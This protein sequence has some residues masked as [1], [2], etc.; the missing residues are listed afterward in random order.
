MHRVYGTD[1]FL[2][3]EVFSQK[4]KRVIFLSISSPLRDHC[5]RPSHHSRT[6][7]GRCLRGK[8]T[9]SWKNVFFQEQGSMIGCHEL[10][11]GFLWCPQRLLILVS[12][13]HLQTQ[14]HGTKFT[15]FDLTIWTNL[16]K[17]S[18]LLKPPRVVQITS[19]KYTYLMFLVY[20][21]FL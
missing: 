18:A 5:S 8:S 7:A 2:S 20:H 16:K 4:A 11:S 19:F 1:Q 6:D 3:L 17:I 14:G 10:C 12:Q 21:V 15:L 9:S 13:A